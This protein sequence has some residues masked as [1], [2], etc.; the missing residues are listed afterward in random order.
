MKKVISIIVAVL[1]LAS[2]TVSAFAEAPK[3]RP[4]DN[5]Y[6]NVYRCVAVSDNQHAHQM[7]IDGGKTWMTVKTEPHTFGNLI[8][9]GTCKV[10]GYMGT[11]PDGDKG[12]TENAE[13]GHN[14]VN[15]Y[16]CVAISP[17]QHAHQ[18]SVDGGKTW[19]TVKINEHTFAALTGLGVCKDCGYSHGDDIKDNDDDDN[20]NGDGD[21]SGNGFVAGDIGFYNGHV[22]VIARFGDGKQLTWEE[23]KAVCENN[24][25]H[26][27]TITSKGEQKFTEKLNDDELNLWIGGFQDNGWA[28]VTEEGWNYTNWTDKYPTGNAEE[29]CSAIAPF[30]WINLKND[31]VDDLDGFIIEFDDADSASA[32]LYCNCAS[33]DCSCNTK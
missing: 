14:Y 27:L 4:Q 9:H 30:T 1:L 7:S 22:Y 32:V 20:G 8:G 21:D 33:E 28:W 31:D 24:G 16:R 13:E 3:V 17:T 23:A 18:M 10:C 19:T 29:A 25:G 11:T 6:F 12:E 26:L 15:V 5:N 2:L